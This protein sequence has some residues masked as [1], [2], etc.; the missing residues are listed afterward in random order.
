MIFLALRTWKLNNF[1]FTIY[2]LRYVKMKNLFERAVKFFSFAKRVGVD[3]VGV[4]C[5]TS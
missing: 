1:L 3:V 2:F 5:V 4:K